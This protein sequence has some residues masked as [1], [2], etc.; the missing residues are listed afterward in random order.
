[1]EEFR[2]RKALEKSARADRIQR[3]VQELHDKRRQTIVQIRSEIGIECDEKGKLGT[4]VTERCQPKPAAAVGKIAIGNPP[5][6]G[7]KT[8]AVRAKQAAVQLKE[9]MKKITNGATK[10]LP[11]EK[12]GGVVENEPARARRLTLTLSDSFIQSSSVDVASITQKE[13]KHVILP[14]VQLSKISAIKPGPKPLSLLGTN[15]NTKPVSIKKQG[16]AGDFTKAP[17]VRKR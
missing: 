17:V 14:S 10:R 5:K 7:P 3:R 11:D 15:V 2:H 1:L 13:N 9:V 12:S 16:T 6:Q 8:F 4:S